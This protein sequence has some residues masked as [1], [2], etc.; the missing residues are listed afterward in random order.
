MVAIRPS[1]R[2]VPVLKPADVRFGSQADMSSATSDVCF[3]PI[4][5]IAIK[6]ERLTR[7]ACGTL[8]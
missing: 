5:D 6:P 7:Y 4:A 2:K 3:G 8:R 1:A